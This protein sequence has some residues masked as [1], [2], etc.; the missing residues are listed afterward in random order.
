[1]AVFGALWGIVEATLGTVLHGINMPFKG[2]VMT[3]CGTVIILIG[4]GLLPDKKGMPILGMGFVAAS[5]KLLSISMVKLPVF[6]SIMAEALL[7]QTGVS[8]MG[9]NVFGYVIAG[10]LASLWPFVYRV[11]IYG[12]IFGGGVRLVYEEAVKTGNLLLGISL[13]SGAAILIFLLAIH[14]VA[15]MISGVLAW[16]GMV[17]LRRR[18]YGE[19]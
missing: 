13:K 4:A 7:M 14:A 3:V 6:F 2:S 17:R 11:L 9:Y 10:M 16:W 18:K 5:I 12:I 15:G 19:T 1:M 8:L